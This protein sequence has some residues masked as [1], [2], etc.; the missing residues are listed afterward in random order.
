MKFALVSSHLPPLPSGQSMTLYRLLRDL[1]ASAYCLITSSN[2]DTDEVRENSP[3]RLAGRLFRLPPVFQ[4]TR[5]Y[6][7]GL[8]KF[9]EAINRPIVIALRG[10]QIAKVIRRENCRAIIAC[11]GGQDLL[12]L[13]AAYL[14][15]RIVGVPFFPYYFDDYYY[16]WSAIPHW[17]ALNGRRL[18]S[19]LIR[20]AERVI[21]PNEFM[22]SE[23]RRRYGIETTV[24]HNPCDISEYESA[25]S[26]APYSS[27]G[28]VRIVYTG[29]IYDAHYDAFLNLIDALRLL[30]RPEL[31]L[32]I[33][34]AHS[35]SE[36]AERGIRGPVVYHDHVPLSAIPAI[37]RQADLLFLPLAFK[38]PYPELVRTSAPGKLGEYL[39]AGRPILAHAPP[40][41]FVVW[42]LRRY[43][44][45][46]VVDRVLDDAT[47]RRTLGERASERAQS[48]FSVS[49]ARAKFFALIK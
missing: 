8:A 23:L 26:G 34:T 25:V 12:D 17:K 11:T 20:G 44:C 22:G 47:L 6:R 43:E 29:A 18:E 5:G 2:Y 27:G 10:R 33:Y 9:R 4:V 49:S 35:H 14:A 38:S 31:K 1:D 48:D 42:Y 41:S 24:I 13:P 21:A 32:H 28:E 46:L 7:Y 19:T 39:A 30:G 40:D 37:Q 16:Q 15:S 36:L 3:R 45:G